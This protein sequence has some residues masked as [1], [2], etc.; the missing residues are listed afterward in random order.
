[1]SHKPAERHLF[2]AWTTE[3]QVLGSVTVQRL[4]RKCSTCGDVQYADDDWGDPGTCADCGAPFEWVRPGKSQPT[5]ACW[6]RCGVHGLGAI[7]YHPEGEVS[8]LSG[9]FCR[10]CMQP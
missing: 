10:A 7:Q 3:P 9:Y 8:G 5:C 2:G 4:M 6:T 1:M